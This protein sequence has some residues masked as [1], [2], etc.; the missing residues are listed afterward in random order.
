MS[1]ETARFLGSPGRS[2]TPPPQI[3]LPARLGPGSRGVVPET[4]SGGLL[5]RPLEASTVSRWLEKLPRWCL[6]FFGSQLDTN[7]GSSCAPRGTARGPE[8]Q[9]VLSFFDVFVYLLSST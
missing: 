8:M 6:D 7:L 1:L 3:Y 4:V 5:G 2:L 9:Y